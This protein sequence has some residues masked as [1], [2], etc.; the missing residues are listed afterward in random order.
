MLAG[1]ASAAWN[2]FTAKNIKDLER[3]QNAAARFA[4]STYGRDTSV[5]KLK[6]SLGWS[7]LQERRS[8]SRLTCLFKMLNG[9]LDVDSR[10]Y[11]TPKTHS[12]TRGHLN[13]FQLKHTRTDV[14]ANSFFPKTTKEWNNLPPSIITQKTTSAFKIEL[15][16]PIKLKK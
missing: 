15:S 16:N 3:V 13:Q 6:E 9:E 12:R 2:P 7:P 4:T 1:Y 10:K 14:Y 11:I 5:T 8:T